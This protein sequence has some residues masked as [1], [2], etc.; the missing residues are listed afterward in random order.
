MVNVPRLRRN[1]LFYPSPSPPFAGERGG[2]REVKL[3]ILP[4]EE[5]SSKNHSISGQTE[6]YPGNIALLDRIY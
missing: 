6:K 3:N 2:V 4:I 1:F 5:L